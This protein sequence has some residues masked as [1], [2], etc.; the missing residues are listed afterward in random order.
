MAMSE[1]LRNT[2]LSAIEESLDAQLRAVRRLRKGQKPE[3]EHVRRKGLS[4]VDMAF[5]ILRKARAPLHVDEM[6]ARIQ[7]AYGRAVD[8]ESLSLCCQRRLPGTTVS[9]APSPTP[10]P[11]AGGT[12]TLLAAFMAIVRDWHAVFPQSA[13]PGAPFAAAEAIEIG[14]SDL[15]RAA[16]LYRELAGSRQPDVRAGVRAEFEGPPDLLPGLSLA[17]QRRPVL[18]TEIGVSKDLEAVSAGRLL[19][20]NRHTAEALLVAAEP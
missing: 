13:L 3:G 10:L 17:Q 8:R 19:P 6:L 4:Q 14:Q 15:H 20:G 11:C 5:D 1:D 18:I 7:S 12:M 9:C 16:A 2:V